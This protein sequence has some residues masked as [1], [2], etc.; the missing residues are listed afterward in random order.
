LPDFAARRGF[1]FGGL[2]IAVSFGATTARA[3]ATPAQLVV[4]MREGG[5][6]VFLRHARTVQDQID[7]GRLGDRAGQRNLSPAGIEQARALGRAFR[8][9]DIG[10][11]RILASPV[12][13][14]RDTAELAFGAGNFTESMEVV[15]DEYA[16]GQVNFMVDS[17]RRLLR[18]PPPSGANLLLVGHRTPL[19]MVTGRRFPDTILPE[20]AMAVFAPAGNEARLLGTLT[21]EELIVVSFAR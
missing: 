5:K 19:E 16:G 9:L 2:S 18:T 15:A 4:A 3:Q 21:A 11:G 14:A 8:E 17:T 1:L 12:F 10:F 7:T 20:G 13:R 6:V